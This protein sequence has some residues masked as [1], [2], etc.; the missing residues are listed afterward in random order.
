MRIVGLSDPG[1]R[2][3]SVV[4]VFGPFLLGLVAGR[5]PALAD[6]EDPQPEE[7]PRWVELDADEAARVK[8]LVCGR[9]NCSG[10]WAGSAGTLMGV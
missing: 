1:K 9:S 2:G 7:D 10:C 5:A 4:A 6:K 8:A 3:C